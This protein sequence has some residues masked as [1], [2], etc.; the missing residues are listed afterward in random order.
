M[1]ESELLAL[2][3]KYGLNRVVDL[4]HDLDSGDIV[5]SINFEFCDQPE[6]DAKIR[7]MLAENNIKVDTTDKSVTFNI[8]REA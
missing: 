8:I 7:E 1:T 5:M 3:T 2:A 4:V 6:Y